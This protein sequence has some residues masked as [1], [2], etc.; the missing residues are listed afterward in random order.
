MARIRHESQLERYSPPGHHGTVNVRLIERDFCGTFEMALGI[1]EPGGT[2]E[3]H[4]HDVEYQ[5]LDVLEGLC[6]VELGDDP[7]VECGPATVIEIPPKVSH[8]V[9]PKDETPLK[10]LVFYSQPLPPRQD[11][12]VD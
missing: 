4:D 6:D 5:A 8:Y 1:L 2:A 7:A 10:I 3:R 11:V 12:A 9:V